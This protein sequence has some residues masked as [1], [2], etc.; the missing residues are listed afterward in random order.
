MADYNVWH[1]TA[2]DAIKQYYA[3]YQETIEPGGIFEGESFN[4]ANFSIEDQMSTIKQEFVGVIRRIKEYESEKEEKMINAFIEKYQKVDKDLGA[5]LKNC[6]KNGDFTSAFNYIHI[7]LRNLQDGINKLPYDLK[8]WVNYMQPYMNVYIRKTAEEAI[9]N[10][11]DIGSKTPKEIAE[12][13]IKEIRNNYKGDPK[14]ASSFENFMNDFEN[15]Y[16]ELV[17]SNKKFG[18]TNWNVPTMD[19]IVEKEK[20]TTNEAI[21][22]K[23][24]AAILDG[25]LNGLSQE[26]FVV[27][28]FGGASTARASRTLKYFTGK[29]QL[30]PT[31]TDMYLALTVGLTAD[32]DINKMIAEATNDADIR[33]ILSDAPEDDFII[34]YSSKDS[35]IVLDKSNKPS[36][37]IGKI[38]GTGSL[39]SR[40]GALTDL[41][42]KSNVIS[43]DNID[44]VIF[45]II[46]NG[47]GLVNQGAGLDQAIQAITSLTIGYMFEDFDDQISYMGKGESNNEIHLYFLSGR[48]VPISTVLSLLIE[49]IEGALS[50]DIIKVSIS[51]SNE[52]FFSEDSSPQARWTWV[53][54]KTISNTKMT[55]IM[56]NQLLLQLGI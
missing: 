12:Y 28:I 46:N 43:R 23:Y 30:V 33:K 31:E 4:P 2:S 29:E 26:E 16:F 1:P 36:D 37:K 14:Y 38:K 19:F 20:V 55:I 13:T 24:V 22:E 9:N 49:Q 35:S 18:K 8:E 17:K 7:F 34:H 15:A 54:N 50:K 48:F 45:T 10:M 47:I 39:D 32:K 51:P 40:I 42:S 27:S 56:A 6:I 44:R 11:K 52:Q 5:L 25:L 53:R 41:A 3:V 21:T